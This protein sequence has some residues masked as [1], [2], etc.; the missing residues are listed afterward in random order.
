MLCAA[1]RSRFVAARPASPPCAWRATSA[2][3]RRARTFA[4]RF[5]I[6]RSRRQVQQN[7]KGISMSLTPGKQ[8]A[9]RE[10]VIVTEPPAA[11]SAATQSAAPVAPSGPAFD[12]IGAARALGLAVKPLFPDASV[13]A[14]MTAAAAAQAPQNPELAAI[15]REQS[16]YYVTHVETDAQAQQVADQL[17]S[18][19]GV[20]KV[21]VK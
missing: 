21:Y 11:P 10:I 15:E 18:V 14:P 9:S 5:R 6:R 13:H 2:P 7:R 19:A 17:K 20:S 16:R 12:M 1:K 3:R 4:K 8:S